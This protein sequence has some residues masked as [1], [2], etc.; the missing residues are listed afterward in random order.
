[1]SDTPSLADLHARL[2][3][4]EAERAVLATLY[5]Y[6]HTIDYGRDADWL[7]CFTE[8]AV[9]HLHYPRGNGEERRFVT[10]DERADFVAAHTRA[11]DKWHKHILVE[12]VITVS[13]D[14]KSA[15]VESYFLRVDDAPATRFIMAQGRYVDELRLCDD[16]KWRFISRRCEI[17]SVEPAD[18]A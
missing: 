9:Y 5:R 10:P 1:M 17:E 2:C 12:P 8:D 4:L 16:G 3:L 15:H 11:P 18:A 7:D 6:G 14:R 13:G